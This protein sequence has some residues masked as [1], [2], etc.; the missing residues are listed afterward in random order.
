[1]PAGEICGFWAE[2][3]VWTAFTQKTL[4]FSYSQG[5]FGQIAVEK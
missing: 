2:V 4:F 1:V 3:E 5:F